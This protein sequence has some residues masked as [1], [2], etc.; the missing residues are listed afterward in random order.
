MLLLQKSEKNIVSTAIQP[1]HQNLQHLNGQSHLSAGNLI[2][3]I[4]HRSWICA[5]LK[6]PLKVGMSVREHL[7]LPFLQKKIIEKT[8]QREFTMS[9]NVSFSKTF[10]AA[11]I[12]LFS[13]VFFFFYEELLLSTCKLSLS[14]PTSCTLLPKHKKR[15][16][17]LHTKLLY[18]SFISKSV[19]SK[20]IS[21]P[22]PL[23]LLIVL[24]KVLVFTNFPHLNIHLQGVLLKIPFNVWFQP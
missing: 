6:C 9:T 14:I 16:E 13:Y 17:T 5:L 23:R 24:Q 10:K 21:G 12:R 2:P 7:S 15:K 8:L 4:K 20:V 18:I 1:E 22:L 11:K 3:K 19:F